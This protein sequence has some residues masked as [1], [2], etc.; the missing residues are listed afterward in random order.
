MPTSCGSRFLLAVSGLNMGALLL[1][2]ISPAP[3]RVLRAPAPVPAHTPSDKGSH[4][5]NDGRAE[6][7]HAGGVVPCQDQDECHHAEKNGASECEEL[8]PPHHG[9]VGG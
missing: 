3:L 4:I 9:Y 7:N 8:S 5:P 2:R 6:D 1:R